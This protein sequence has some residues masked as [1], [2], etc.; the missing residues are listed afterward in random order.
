MRRLVE[1]FR[2]WEEALA[3]LDGP[4]GDDLLTLE[5]RV[6]WLEAEVGDLR[7]PKN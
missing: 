6:W 2:S 1:K 3:G 4:R 5:E 7:R